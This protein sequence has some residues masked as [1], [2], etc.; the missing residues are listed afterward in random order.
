MKTD[1]IF[2][3]LFAEF[4][5]IFFELLG[6]SISDTQDYQFRSVEIKQTAFRIDGVFLP[7][8]N[9]SD[10]TVYF[11]EVQFQKDELLYNRL[12]AELFLFC[13][14][15]PATYD[16]YAVI[17]YP[18]RSLEPDNTKLYQ[19][20]LDSSK[21]QRV[22]LDE[23]EPTSKSLGIGIIKLVVEPEENAANRARNLI[24][25]TRQE[26]ANPLSSQAIIDLIETIIVYKFPHLSREEVENMLKLNA[27]KQ[28][29]VYQEALEEGREEGREEGKLSAVP[30]LLKAGITVEEIAE[31]LQINLETVRKIAQQQT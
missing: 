30:L 4:P 25:Q 6:R 7:T 19:I 3:Q 16:W 20:L 28:T 29:R 1:S 21:V 18:M 11:C 23:I 31:Q 24:S 13:N 22:Y 12:F 15:N 17:I 8:A 26:I 5:N 2:Y 9:N 27:L 10:Q 14:Q